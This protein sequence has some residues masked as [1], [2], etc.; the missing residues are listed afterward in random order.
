MFPS[1]SVS[2]KPIHT[3]SLSN[4]DMN[5]CVWIKTRTQ[6]TGNVLWTWLTFSRGSLKVYK[7]SSS[8]VNITFVQSYVV[9]NNVVKWLDENGMYTLFVEGFLNVL[10]I[11]GETSVVSES[12]VES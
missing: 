4:E 7:H 5:L 2:D 6:L 9:F 11:M 10:I 12:S 8:N 1:F 3:L